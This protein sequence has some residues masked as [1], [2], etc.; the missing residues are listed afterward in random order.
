MLVHLVRHG[1][2]AANAGQATTD[3][4]EIP[5]TA[6]GQ[7]Q[8]EAFARSLAEPP[9][10][11]VC[12]PFR[13]AKE[14]AA[15]VASRFGLPVEVWPIQEFTYLSPARCAGTT[16]AERRAWVEAYWQAAA[17]DLV[18]GPGAESFAQ[19]IDRVRAT[20]GRLRVYPAGS[21]V[22]MVGHGQFMQAMRWWA[23]EPHRRLPLTGEHVQRFRQID[24]TNPLGNC[25]GYTLMPAVDGWAIPSRP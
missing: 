20:L 13:R 19:M 9:T 2:S 22:L 4:A 6:A 24:Q 10:A 11:I 15:P 23:G 1:E 7:D 21:L 8:A 17:P 14:T 12:S 18:D 25:Q 16:V 5:L 3:P